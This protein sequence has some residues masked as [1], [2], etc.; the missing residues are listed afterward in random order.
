[1][2]IGFDSGE[3]CGR[4]SCKGEISLREIENC[5]CHL[6]APCSSCT[7][8]RGQC[9]ECGWDQR[10]DERMNDYII[11]FDKT[12]GR[13][14]EFTLRPLDRS[15]IDW[16]SKVHTNASMIKEGTYPDGTT[17]EQVEKEVVGTFG[18]RFEHFGK[19][20][21]KYIAYTD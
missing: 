11:S 9:G 5:S 10:N 6:D 21:F 1:V 12:K 7:E 8:P 14:T 20:K 16:H 2:N 4:A 19:G 18:G 3:I 15:K 17:R 13:V